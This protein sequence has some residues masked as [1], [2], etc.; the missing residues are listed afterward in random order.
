MARRIKFKREDGLRSGF[1][2]TGV[3]FL[4]RKKIPFEYETQ[5]LP[6]T[7]FYKPDFIFK[8]KEDGHDIILEFKGYFKGTNR[9][10]MAA[11]KRQNPEKD[12]RFIF[13]QNNK[14]TKK[15]K[16]RYTDWCDKHGF[17]SY[18]VGSSSQIIP[19]DWLKEFKRK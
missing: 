5:K 2:G 4:N 6:Y 10:M 18:V 3:A 14:L 13:M 16:M 11:V 15:S 7:C 9:T 1:E 19:E 8:S 17:P 12:I